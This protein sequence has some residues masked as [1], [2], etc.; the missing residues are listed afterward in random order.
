MQVNS[1]I[2]RFLA[3]TVLLAAFASCSGTED[4]QPEAPQPS[5][6]TL[7]ILTDYASITSGGEVYVDFRI[8]PYE[9]AFDYT[10]EDGSCAVALATQYG[11]TEDLNCQIAGIEPLGSDPMDSGK[12]RV[13]LKDGRKQ[14]TYDDVYQ[15]I[16]TDEKGRK[17]RSGT[18]KIHCEC[19]NLTKTVLAAGL[20]VVVIETVDR[21]EPT[22]E[23]VSHPPGCAGA[24]IRNAT[25]VPGRVSILD[26]KNILYESGDYKDG[27]SGM[28]V[29]IRGNTSAY[30][31]KK[32]YKVKL[33]KKADLLFRGDDK[34]YKDKDWLLLRYDELKMMAGFKVNE[35]LGITW[36][37]GF[38]FV[39]VIFNGKN[40]G[41]YMLTE[42][43]K[44]NDECRLNVLKDEGYIIEYDA[45]WWNEDVYF[46]N[47][48]TYSMAYTFK[49]PEEDEVTE[50]Q[51]AYIKG[52]VAQVEKS[53]IEGNY[54]EYIDVLSFARWLLGQDILGNLDSAG[55]NMYLTKYDKTTNSKL[56]MANLWDFDN[57]YRMQDQW[58]NIHM[59]GAFYFPHLLG[60][61]NPA[62]RQTYVSLSDGGTQRICKV[63]STYM[64]NFASSNTGVAVDAS[65]VLDNARWHYGVPTV[66]ESVDR[67]CEWFDSR[68]GWLNNAMAGLR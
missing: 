67:A 2:Y 1:S 9:T 29:R 56:A 36:T 38:Q 17:A 59:T 40:R 24:G 57:I 60:S 47:G 32:P 25:K 3:K 35:L 58:S 21:E 15:F 19:D 54:E 5:D 6:V 65:I 52:F 23:Y 49:Y 34:K 30:A 13:L 4:K 8:N 42:A 62:F 64:K 10:V 68:A 31:S 43:V 61:R 46:T 12:Y 55:S 50:E 16:F 53:I 27:E 48:W 28:T 37:P 44:R 33:Q 11:V 41:L 22:C 7:S 26:R 39:N 20:P 51:V 63:L 45:Y 18:F 14:H 66:Q